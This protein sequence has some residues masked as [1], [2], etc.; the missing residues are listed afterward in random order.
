M[1]SPLAVEMRD[2]WF[3]YNGRPV[4]HEVNLEIG[5]RELVCMVGANGSGKT[6]LVKLLLGLLAPDR[7]R[8]SV[9]GSRPQ[10]A[11]SRVGYT[12]QEAHFDARFPVTVADVAMMGCVGRSWGLGIHGRADRRAARQAL[13]EVGLWDLRRRPF[14]ELS[15]GQRQRVLIARAL[16]AQPEL[17]ILDEPTAGL[18]IAVEAGFYELL[19][20][21]AQRL[22][23]VLVSHDIGF[24]SDTVGKVICVKGTVAV[25][26]TSELTGEVIR[27]LY[28]V[29]VRL[30]RHD[31]DCLTQCEQEGAK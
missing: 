30:V 20:R 29:D 26:P 8:V 7:G 10:D 23:V 21:L 6:T 5:R 22:T 3:S 15:G 18:D 17:L 12:P 14:A 25:H 19:R 4:L 27:D 1:A 24:V 16:A 13:E 31:H 2:V 9:L 28:G 11:R